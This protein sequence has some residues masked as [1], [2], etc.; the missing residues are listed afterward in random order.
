MKGEGDGCF[1]TFDALDEAMAFAGRLRKQLSAH[2][3]RQGFAPAVRIGPH[4]GEAVARGRDWFGTAVNVAARICAA[5]EPG[6]ILVSA[7]SLEGRTGPSVGAPRAIELK[8]LGA[9]I[10]VVALAS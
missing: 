7:T 3:D 9:P 8:G 10:D 4:R 2:R 5:A 1:L 6:G